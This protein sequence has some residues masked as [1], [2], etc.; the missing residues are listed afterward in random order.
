MDVVAKEEVEISD[1]VD[2]VENHRALVEDELT[3][4]LLVRRR[5]EPD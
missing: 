3:P 4:R 1:R 5:D 2:G